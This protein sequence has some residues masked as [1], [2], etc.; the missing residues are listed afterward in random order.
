MR[1]PGRPSHLGERFA[2]RNL[3]M[4]TGTQEAS[5]GAVRHRRRRSSGGPPHGLQGHA[6]PCVGPV[7]TARPRTP[8][9]PSRMPADLRG[10]LSRPRREAFGTARNSAG[11]ALR[12]PRLGG[13]QV[14]PNFEKAT[15]KVLREQSHAS[16]PYRGAVRRGESKTTGQHRH[17]TRLSYYSI[18]CHYMI[19]YSSI[20]H[21]NIVQYIILYSSIVSYTIL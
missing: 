16:R 3:A 15:G 10:P 17:T 20:S 2:Q 11:I 1:A 4:R 18:L 5:D 8:L 9:A 19:V 21:Y 6:V 12:A 14:P 7:L 13:L